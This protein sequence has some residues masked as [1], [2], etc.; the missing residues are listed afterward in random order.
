M[1]RSMCCIG[2]NP[3]GVRSSSKKSV[4][5]LPLARA[6]SRRVTILVLATAT[7]GILDLVF[8][9]TYMQSV[10]M[11]EL[12][13]LARFM[14]GVGGAGQLIRFKLLTIAMSS[15]LLYLLRRRPGAEWCAW[16][17]L[18]AL[19]ALSLHWAQYT[20]M[21]EDLAPNFFAPSA[22]ADQRWVTITD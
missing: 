7:L 5:S 11:I 14:I 15:G 12:N 16:F 1:P 3:F 6:R 2:S 13:P 21:S 22:A 9:L 17:S 4:G 10:G 18:I 19:V 20:R 8:T